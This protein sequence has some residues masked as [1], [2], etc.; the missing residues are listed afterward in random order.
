MKVK[1]DK[2][3]VDLLGFVLIIGLVFSIPVV[4]QSSSEYYVL[5][6]ITGT[7]FD[8]NVTFVTTA[9]NITYR[10]IGDGLAYNDVYYVI[11][12]E[13]DKYSDK[14]HFRVGYFIQIENGDTYSVAVLENNNYAYEFIIKPTVDCVAG[15]IRY[16][17]DV[18]LIDV[19]G[20]VVLNNINDDKNNDVVLG[21]YANNNIEMYY[22]LV[23]L[24]APVALGLIVYNKRKPKISK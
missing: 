16:N 1:F 17:G 8:I 11:E 7:D 4:A 5:F 22:L 12:Y 19:K 21:G 2:Y 24:I 20:F 18:E 10:Y 3:F 6:K 14:L 15:Y 9:G 13:N 23:T